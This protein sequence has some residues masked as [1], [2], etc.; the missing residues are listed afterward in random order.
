[1][2]VSRTIFYREV[3]FIYELG[4]SRVIYYDWGQPEIHTLR[5]HRSVFSTDVF[6]ITTINVRLCFVT[7]LCQKK[8]PEMFHSTEGVLRVN[9]PCKVYPIYFLPYV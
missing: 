9:L 6:R 7:D 5:K 8:P 2:E 3:E 1:M 4:L